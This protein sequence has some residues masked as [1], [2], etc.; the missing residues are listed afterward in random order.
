MLIQIFR[1]RFLL[2]GF[3]WAVVERGITGQRGAVFAG[4]VNAARFIRIKIL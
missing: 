1:Q 2:P 4:R 3:E